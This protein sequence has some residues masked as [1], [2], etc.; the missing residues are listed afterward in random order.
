MVLKKKL[1]VLIRHA[2]ELTANLGQAF[3]FQRPHFL[4]ILPFTIVT[5]KRSLQ[6][7]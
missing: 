4:T 3:L 2:S 5:L 1:S 6:A 7:F